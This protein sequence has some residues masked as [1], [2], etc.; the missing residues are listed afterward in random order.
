M[1]GST[2]STTFFSSKATGVSDSGQLVDP[3]TCRATTITNPT[4]L[5]P[6]DNPDLVTPTINPTLLPLTPNQPFVVSTINQ[7]SAATSNPPLPS[8]NDD[9]SWLSA[10]MLSRRVRFQLN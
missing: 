2:T 8:N 3:P 1:G 6:T 5:A 9:S 7:P 10:L 4:L